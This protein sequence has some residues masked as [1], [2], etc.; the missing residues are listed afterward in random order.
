MFHAELRM[1][2]HVV[3]RFN[4]ADAELW[5]GFIEPLLGGADFELEGHE[6]S[7]RE[8]QMTIYE[9]PALR[10]DQLALG[11]GWQN[12]ERSGNDVTARVLATARE[13][14]SK[15]VAEPLTDDHAGRSEQLR[16]RLLGR[17]SAGPAAAPDILALAAELPGERS[18]A[19]CEQLAAQAVW[20]LLAQ[21]RCELVPARPK[22]RD[23]GSAQNSGR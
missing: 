23:A 16:E 6:F 5:H 15:R 11:H 8:T 3:R 19:A 18:P 2:M 12:A 22:P 7:P 14:L 10:P 4:L 9:G 21:G 13:H 1:G 17:L 20:E